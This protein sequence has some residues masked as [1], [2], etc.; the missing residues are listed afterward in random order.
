MRTTLIYLST[1]TLLMPLFG[2]STHTA[3]AAPVSLQVGALGGLTH[4]QGMLG[5]FFAAGWQAGGYAWIRGPA[6]GLRLQADYHRM[7]RTGTLFGTPRYT[8]KYTLTAVLLQMTFS[9]VE[10][11]RLKPYL[12]I[13]GGSVN[14]KF[15]D[16]DATYDESSEYTSRDGAFSFGGGLEVS[17]GRVAAL[18]E[19]Q[20]LVAFEPNDSL[21]MLMLTIGFGVP[22]L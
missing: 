19:A 22:I 3:Q 18:L 10:V 6:I 4:P 8:G 16:Y 21:K 7:K 13:G 15:N 2:V 11:S 9:P 17:I 14:S 12:M 1:L 20:Y 5:E